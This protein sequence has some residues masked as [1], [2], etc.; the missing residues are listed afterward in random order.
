MRKKRIGVLNPFPKKGLNALL[1]KGFW[2]MRGVEPLS[3][4]SG[5]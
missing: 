5:T 3:E 2:K 4:D 1:G